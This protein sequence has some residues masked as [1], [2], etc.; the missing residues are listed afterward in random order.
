MAKRGFDVYAISSPGQRLI[1]FGKE[2]GVCVHAVTMSR[3]ITPVKDM[4]SL[5]QI[6]RVIYS[7]KPDIV[8]AHTPKAG[9]LGMIAAWLARVPVR[10]Y[11]IHGQPSMTAK[12]L[13]KTILKYAEK[14]SC[15]LAC[16]VICV[17]NSIRDII[18]KDGL[19]SPDKIKVLCNGS[20][21]G[22]DTSSRYN[23]AHINKNDI[24]GLRKSLGLQTNSLTI[25]FVG[26]IVR[27]KGIAELAEAWKDLRK[28]FQ[29]LHLII[30]GEPEPHN[31]VPSALLE[32]MR[33][34]P[35]VHMIGRVDK[36]LMPTIYSLLDILVLPTYREG[37]GNVAIEAAAMEVPVVATSVPGVIDAVQD[38]ITGTLVPPYNA[39]ELAKAIKRYLQDPILRLKHGQSG[40]KRVMKDFRPEF[41]QAAMFD[42]YMTLIESSSNHNQHNNWKTFYQVS[43]RIFDVSAAIIIGTA[44]LPLILSIATAI[45]LTM[46]SP[47]F[48]KETRPGKDEKEFT[49]WKFRSMTYNQ[50]AHGNLLPDSKRL[51]RLGKL[52]R[53]TSMD[54]LPQLWNVLKG[55]MSFVGPRPLKTDY[56]P[57]YTARERLRHKV[58]PGITGLSQISGRNMLGWNERLEKDVFYVE[59]QGFLLDAKIIL[60]T[61]IQ[62]IS[63]KDVAEVPGELLKPLNVVRSPM[64][65]HIASGGQ[66]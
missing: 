17:S 25:G 55:E 41:I 36:K 22:V 64:Q 30:A 14:L 15:L 63:G 60:L 61:A 6:W 66:Q 27:D 50:D 19:C 52:L 38:G 59:H 49:I 42:E 24:A 58:R 46:G 3:C 34:D 57:F 43:K 10:I 53:K 29:N 54:E 62:C 26:R 56:L 20:V 48:Y 33:N 18:I 13:R 4:L 5:W 45:K 7:I 51:T 28:D 35:R 32:H 37:F 12:G 47:V 23:P 16:R 8:N 40:R 65:K 9:L 21:N 39:A 44:L 31:P 2:Q 11:H 1:D